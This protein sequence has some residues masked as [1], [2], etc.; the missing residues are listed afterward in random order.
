MVVVVNSSLR[1]AVVFYIY[2]NH[3]D[4]SRYDIQ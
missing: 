3:C 2:I 4:V 1:V